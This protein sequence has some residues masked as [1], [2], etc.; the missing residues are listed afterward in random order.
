MSAPG[1]GRLRLQVFGVYDD[2]LL[3]AE[4]A[5]LLAELTRA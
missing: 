5:T 4:L 1:K 2:L 3:G